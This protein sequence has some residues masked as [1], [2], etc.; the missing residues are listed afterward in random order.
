MIRIVDRRLYRLVL[1]GTMVLALAACGRKSGLDAPPST[2]AV[3]PPQA[4]RQ[5]SLGEQTDTFSGT[6]RGPDQPSSPPR[7]GTVPQKDSFFLDWLLK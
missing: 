3:P 7:P 5:P 6:T 4:E 2:S 1:A